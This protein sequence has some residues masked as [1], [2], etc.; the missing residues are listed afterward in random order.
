MGTAL[1]YLR[2]LLER[3]GLE[4]DLRTA[5]S[6]LILLVLL[7][8]LPIGLFLIRGELD[9]LPK[10][11]GE[12]IQLGDGGCIKLNKDKKKVVDCPTV[13]LKLVNP[14]FNIT[15]SSTAPSSQPSAGSSSSPAVSPSTAVSPSPSPTPG[16][17]QNVNV[18]S[19]NNNI[20]LAL[21]SIKTSGGSVYVPAG[22]YTISDKIR[23]YS[24]TTLAGDGMGATIIKFAD[25]IALTD[26]MANDSSAGQQNI[27]VRDLTLQGPALSEYIN[28]CCYGL[29]LENLDGAFVINVEVN[30]FSFDGIYLGYKHKN[31]VPLGVK[32]A[33]VTGCKVTNSSRSGIYLAD[34][35]NV[36]VDNC[37]VTGNGKFEPIDGITA[38]PDNGSVV[39]N[40]KILSNN[41]TNNRGNGI[42]LGS[43]HEAHKDA[44]VT[45]VAVC[46]NMADPNDYASLRQHKCNDGVSGNIFVN[47][48][49]NG[50]FDNTGG[51]EILN[52]PQSAC[53]IPGSLASLPAAPPKPAALNKEIKNTTSF[54]WVSGLIG[55]VFAQDSDDNFTGTSGDDSDDVFTGASGSPT[56]S[57]GSPVSSGSGTANNVVR[58]RLAESQAGL[59][60]A[61]WREFAMVPNK[62]HWAFGWVSGLI[63]DVFAQDSDDNFTGT[64][65]DDSDDVFASGSP[66]VSGSS[67]PG[68]S[69]NPTY[70]IGKQFIT[71]N[72]Q[73]T[74]T[75]PGVKQ[76]WVQ[77]QHPDGS[78]RVDHVTFD[79][80]DKVP[81]I[82]G[83]ACNL[84]ISK[85]SLRITVDGNFFGTT[86]GKVTSVSPTGTPDIQGW[87][88]KQ[89]IASLK[90]PNIPINEGQRFQIKVERP[91]GFES[92]TAV[93]A[94]DKSLVSLGARIFCREPG[95]FDATDVDLTIVSSPDDKGKVSKVEEKVTISKD[96]EINN[97][98]TQLQVGKNYAV[99]IKAP[100][101]LRRTAVFTAMEGT[102][103]ILRPDGAPFILP[104]GDIAPKINV[105][106]Q[107][108]TLDRAE[109]IRQWKILGQADAKLTGDFNRDT[110]VNS[111]DWA[112]MQYDFGSS[113]EPL[114]V[115]IPG[116]ASNTIHIGSSSDT[117]FIPV[118]SATP[119]PSLRPSPS[120]NP[121]PS[122]SPSASPISMI[123]QSNK[124]LLIS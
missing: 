87:T 98:K 118:S 76:I 91:D 95:K 24:H 25:N 105:D 10:A 97:L 119:V 6:L 26:M 32:N 122:P 96:G 58:Y 17:P 86:I 27:V 13:P 7:I 63:G 90:N 104:I 116:S 117:L 71:T 18:R 61:Q 78:T 2:E 47:N 123:L 120:V 107:I 108:N 21:D 106:G 29:K 42:G 44:P 56:A 41:V 99:S 53:D 34:T 89:I 67:N 8:L 28:N 124:I 77:F 15:N 100:S 79:L 66:V 30:D 14:F 115:E 72:F 103:E 45:N 101:S 46:G 49:D 82:T 1:K 114:P 68:S 57:A 5:T 74:N 94:V 50:E 84:D 52:G 36:V 60:S 111:I 85:Q 64:S 19:F 69:G 73:L 55:D 16:T 51:G 39:K 70:S 93:C 23:L 59:S 75:Q 65:G 62:T 3:I 31:G 88:N 4:L 33:R 43:C 112:C 48:V 40:S 37:T 121:S 12:L 102:T 20:Q 92:P 80:V 81:Q 110:R 83:L 54:G 113:D 22:T 35:D 9:F 109:L 11:A 38:G